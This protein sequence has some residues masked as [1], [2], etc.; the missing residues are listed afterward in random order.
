MTA[1]AGSDEVL[2]SRYRRAVAAC[3]VMNLRQASRAIT[4]FYD[5]ALR[6]AGLRATQLNILMAIEV[7]APTTVSAIAE[8]VG[9]DRTTMTRNVQLLRKRGLIET[10]RVTLTAR[11]RAAAAAALPLWERAQAT[12]VD[13][14]GGT[15]WT[16]LLKELA[17][18]KAAVKTRPRRD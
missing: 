11:G 10:K 7:G 14:L 17:A 16:A 18:A 12:V 13:S 3:A 6:P 5:A 1:S 15:R 8:I 9:T 4:S 2:L